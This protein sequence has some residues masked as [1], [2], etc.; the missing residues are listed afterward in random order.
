[1][2]IISLKDL[3][4]ETNSVFS[5][6]EIWKNPVP[7][8]KTY[9]TYLAPDSYAY[10]SV[11]N[12]VFSFEL[13]AHNFQDFRKFSLLSFRDG[14]YPLSR[15][16]ALNPTPS[17]SDPVLIVDSKLSA[18]VPMAWRSQVF[19]RD[20]FVTPK[21]ITTPS[22][23]LLLLVSP[24]KD[25]L[26]LDLLEMEIKKIKDKMH[27][28]ESVLIYLSSC[29]FY[30][31]EDPEYDFSWGHK[32][33][34]LILDQLPNKQ[35]SILDFAEYNAKN[36]SESTFHFLNPLNFYFTDSYLMHDLLQRG[37]VPL[38]ST[39]EKKA[40]DISVNISMNHGFILHSRYSSH[41]ELTPGPEVM[42]KVFKGV[43][44]RAP[45]ESLSKAIKL[46]TKEFKDWSSAT[47]RHLLKENF[48]L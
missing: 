48:N 18:I 41:H 26:P 40:E 3:L 47:A 20:L 7:M 23:E 25:S 2:K 13:E 19:L 44:Y 38:E 4:K 22:K 9:R 30:G 45:V 24:D 6:E 35:V 34:K 27:S 28:F 10:H 31:E 21:V 37:G 46:S 5:Y 14:L 8:N 29:N 17:G 16:F 32:V 11:I 1:M 12:P 43:I 15:F 33:L 39:L 42:E 36:V